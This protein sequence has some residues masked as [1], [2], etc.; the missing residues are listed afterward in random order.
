MASLHRRNGNLA[1]VAMYK[2]GKANAWTRS[3]THMSVAVGA[4]AAMTEA[5][6]IG[7]ACLRG[8]RLR[9]SFSWDIAADWQYDPAPQTEIEVRF[10]AEGARGRV[11]SSG[12]GGSNAIVTIVMKCAPSSRRLAT[13]RRHIAGSALDSRPRR[14]ILISGASSAHT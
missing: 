6:A 13:L 14:E 7:V 4:S 2:I 12:I 11:W 5:G 1:A 3:Q 9:G 8:S 10:I